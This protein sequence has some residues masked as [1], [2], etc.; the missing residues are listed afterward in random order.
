MEVNSNG[1]AFHACTW[2]HARGPWLDPF[3][4]WS[5][6]ILDIAH[7]RKI[8]ESVLYHGVWMLDAFLALFVRFYLVEV[9]HVR[10]G[11]DV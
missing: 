5:P 11:E 6:E 7:V 9:S 1:W 2:L 4:T 3:L 10:D 8:A